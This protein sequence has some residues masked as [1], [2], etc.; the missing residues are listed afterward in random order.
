MGLDTNE[1]QELHIHHLF[2]K[3]N[4]ENFTFDNLPKEIRDHLGTGLFA[5]IMAMQRDGFVTDLGYQRKFEYSQTGRNRYELLRQKKR[6]EAISDWII[7][8]TLVA[9]IVSAVYGVLTYYATVE[10]SNQPILKPAPTTEQ[11][12][13]EQKTPP[14][15]DTTRT[16]FVDSST[17]KNGKN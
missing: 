12:K 17:K 2:V 1:K 8:I 7:K 3:H 11:P 13:K 6:S 10:A 14:Q 5:I 15:Y 16:P 9:A 4:V